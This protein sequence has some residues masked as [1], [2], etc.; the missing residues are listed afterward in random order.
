MKGYFWYWPA[1]GLKC[2]EQ[3]KRQ[4]MLSFDMDWNY[5][6]MKD[7]QL[8]IFSKCHFLFKEQNLNKELHNLKTVRV[9][10]NF[11]YDITSSISW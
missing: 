5:N 6:N 8:K 10:G 1:V 7:Y 2:G 11:V 4:F 3:H 9:N